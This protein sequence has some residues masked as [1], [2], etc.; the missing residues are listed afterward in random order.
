MRLD[1]ENLFSHE[2]AITA[3]A[4]SS[5]VI[6]LH[7]DRNIGVGYPLGIAIVVTEDFATNDAL[8]VTVETADNEAFD[9]GEVDLVSAEAAV[10]ELTAGYKFPILYVP[11]GVK[12]FVRLS[13]TVSGSNATAGAVTA[14]LA[15][16][17]DDWKAYPGVIGGHAAGS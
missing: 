16:D 13:Y 6:D 10:A 7:E 15:I 4:A 1:Y 11:R 12:R 9:E 2:Q 17:Q 3:D 14:G 5:N 8:T